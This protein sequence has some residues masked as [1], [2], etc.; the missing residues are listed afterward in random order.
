VYYHLHAN[1]FY[2]NY[3]IYINYI[4]FKNTS[5]KNPVRKT[6]TSIYFNKNSKKGPMKIQK[7]M[8]RQIYDS[9]CTPT[10]ECEIM[11]NSGESVRASIPHGKS[12]GAGEAFEFGTSVHGIN[13]AIDLINNQL[14]P[15]IIGLEPNLID[16]D[17]M[18][19][20]FDGT[21]QKSK[22][23][24][25]TM[26][27]ISTA[28][29]KAQ[30]LME[31]I[32]IFECIGYLYDIESVSIPLCMF[33]IFNGGLHAQNKLPIQEVL[34]IPHGTATFKEA[35]EMAVIVFKE[36]GY[37]LEKNGFSS[38]IGDEGGYAPNIVDVEKLLDLLCTII[39]SLGFASNIMLALDMAASYW[40]DPITHLYTLNGNTVETE[41]LIA[42]YEH[43]TVS[44]PLY[45]IEDGLS[46]YDWDGWKNLTNVL[47]KTLQLIGDDL[48]VTNPQR[49]AQGIEKEVANAVIIKPT[50]IGTITEAL[51]SAKLAQT[52]NYAAIVS[53][54]SGETSDDF[55]ADFAVGCNASQ[56]KAGGLLRGER[57]AKY[58]R[59]L[60]IEEYLM[61]QLARSHEKD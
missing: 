27:A 7:V 6:H 23:G 60:K 4:Y 16:I 13:E 39:E 59:L 42:W 28:I 32:E 31:G 54:R 51:Q 43:L 46:Q 26:L 12:K 25:N 22:L 58:H 3:A 37:V 36:V 38:T 33:N 5:N 21:P 15:L 1:T 50:Q 56:F 52:Y 24:S 55:I 57:L 61:S 40:Y 30:A 17:Q 53:H 41:E 8:A 11:L 49:I 29:C 34:F 47:G 44:Y 18:L 2:F 10:I 48:F 19:I 20:E 45:A 35:L 9:R 14:G